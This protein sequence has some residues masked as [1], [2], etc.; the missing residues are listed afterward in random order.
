MAIQKRGVRSNKT[1]TLLESVQRRATRMILDLS[2]MHYPNMLIALSIN[3]LA[4]RRPTK[5]AQNVQRNRR[6]LPVDLFVTENARSATRG[7]PIKI[8]KVHPRF[9]MRKYSFTQWVVDD[10]SRLPG[11]A[12]KSKIINQFKGHKLRKQATKI[13]DERLEDSFPLVCMSPSSI[14]C[15]ISGCLIIR[16]RQ[17]ILRIYTGNSSC[18]FDHVCDPTKFVSFYNIP[19]FQRHSARQ[20]L[21]FKIPTTKVPRN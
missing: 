18:S 3:T 13:D 19:T 21:V 7:H 15:C 1:T 14:Y 12:V 10:W 17:F 11:A 8:T 9:D 6:K 4:T 2:H 16:T 20:L 5:G